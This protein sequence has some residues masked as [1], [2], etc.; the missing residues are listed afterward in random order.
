MVGENHKL[1]NGYDV[2][3]S[4]HFFNLVDNGISLRRVRSE[5][6]EY[7]DLRTWKIRQQEFV[8]NTRDWVLDYSMKDG[9]V[10][11]ERGIYE[12]P[13]AQPF[14]PAPVDDTTIKRA[15]IQ[16]DLLDTLGFD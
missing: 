14:A 6:E 12:E 2:S 16:P 15:E 4:S 10:Y 5:M 13:V 11:L 7:V 1:V 9:G 8:G 3:G